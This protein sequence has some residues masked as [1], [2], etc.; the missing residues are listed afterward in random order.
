[1]KFFGAKDFFFV[2]FDFINER[3]IEFEDNNE[4]PC[5]RFKK[6]IPLK[7]D[8]RAEGTHESIPTAWEL[9]KSGPIFN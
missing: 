4:N 2:N 1:M 8:F 6:R 7:I 5:S 9:R 3:K